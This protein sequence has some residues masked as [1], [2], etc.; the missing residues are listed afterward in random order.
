M[1]EQLLLLS[2]SG[3][4]ST[5]VKGMSIASCESERVALAVNDV[6]YSKRRFHSQLCA[7]RVHV[8]VPRFQ[9]RRTFPNTLDAVQLCGRK[10]AQRSI[11]DIF[12]LID[13]TN[14][15]LRSTLDGAVRP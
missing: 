8:N 12:V 13:C 10:G 5:S 6:A 14:I 1:Y 7:R 4:M 2:S 3:N 11:V 15:L 9:S